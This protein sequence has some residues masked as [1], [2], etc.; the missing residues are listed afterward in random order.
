MVCSPL[1]EKEVLGKILKMHNVNSPFWKF[2]NNE[3]FIELN[4]ELIILLLIV[5]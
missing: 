2:H 5:S 1:P 4:M 3:L